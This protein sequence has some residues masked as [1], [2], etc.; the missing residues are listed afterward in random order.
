MRCHRSLPHSSFFPDCRVA[1]T[2]SHVTFRVWPSTRH[3]HH[4]IS[5]QSLSSVNCPM[6]AVN[7]AHSSP[8]LL[9][10]RCF[11]F[12]FFFSLV[13]SF[14]H[15]FVRSSGLVAAVMHGNVCPISL[16]VSFS[17]R[18]P[19][20]PRRSPII[21]SFPFI[22][23][24]NGQRSLRSLSTI[25]LSLCRFPNSSRRGASAVA[26]FQRLTQSPLTP[27]FSLRF[28]GFAP[29]DRRLRSCDHFIALPRRHS[30]CLALCFVLLRASTE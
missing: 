11:F 1:F 10:D 8:P 21:H 26:R 12:S 24:I 5:S 16:H 3:S 2:R 9:T 14:I 25:H 13:H 20:A 18:H 19:L 30:R 27:F 15:S 22:P 28:F 23:T 4:G 7:T 17:L 29:I 6:L